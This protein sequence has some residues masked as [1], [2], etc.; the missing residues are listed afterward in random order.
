MKKR[1]E[2]TRISVGKGMTLTIKEVRGSS[3]L[4]ARR[5]GYEEV[6]RN[7]ATHFHWKLSGVASKL[8]ADVVQS[9]TFDPKK[10]EVYNLAITSSAYDI[11]CA[12]GFT[13]REDAIRNAVD[14]AGR[15]RVEIDGYGAVP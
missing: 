14:F 1:F 15:N 13:S 8:G 6:S 3:T 5:E 12:A 4:Y 10:Q 2:E 11:G 7:T 9:E